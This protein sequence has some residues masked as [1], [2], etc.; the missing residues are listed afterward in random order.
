[1]VKIAIFTALLATITVAQTT[2]PAPSTTILSIFE[3][4]NSLNA[5][6]FSNMGG[7]IVN[8]DAS[9]NQTIIAI[10]CVQSLLAY[11]SFSSYVLPMTITSGP[12]TF[13]WS[14]S[15]TALSGSVYSIAG[16]SQNCAVIGSTQSANC[17]IYDNHWHLNISTTSLSS[18]SATVE[19]S[20]AQI[21]YDLLTVT[22]GIE[23]LSPDSTA[24]VSSI[25]VTGTATSSTDP[26]KNSSKAWIAGPDIGDVVGCT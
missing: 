5:Q 17:L 13:A 4:N 23:K 19:L 14:M 11:C 22:A 12:S 15:S 7:S 2:T 25:T 21:T 26:G 24:S 20:A 8:V 6:V 16:Q 18:T 1:M 9:S 10:N 3:E